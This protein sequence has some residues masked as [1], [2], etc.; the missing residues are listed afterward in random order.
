MPNFSVPAGTMPSAASSTV[1]DKSGKSHSA[2]K[3]VFRDST[4]GLPVTVTVVGDNNL[5][6]AN[7]TP[8][9]LGW[10]DAFTDSSA[11][12]RRHVINLVLNDANGKPVT[13]FDP[14]VELRVTLTPAEQ[15]GSHLVYYDPNAGQ[16][17]SFTGAT[18]VGA[19][20]VV[21]ISAWFG[22]PPVGVETP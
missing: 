11:T 7:A 13:A 8:T 12:N 6:A 2:K 4:G 21:T 5:G 9:A 3:N 22:D 16:W 17:K 10:K 19:E 1:T 15:K 20:I 14:P 18:R